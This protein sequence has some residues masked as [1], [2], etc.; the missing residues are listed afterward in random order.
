MLRLFCRDY[1]MQIACIVSVCSTESRAH[2]L[3]IQGLL[4]VAPHSIP[5][6]G[7]IDGCMDK[8][9]TEQMNSIE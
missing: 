8:F 9:M 5:L 4:L 3:G 1:S 6:D 7:W 2:V